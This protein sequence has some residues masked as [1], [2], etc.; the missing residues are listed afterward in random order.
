LISYEANAHILKNRASFLE[1]FNRLS[2]KAK[3]PPSKGFFLPP[4]SNPDL[5]LA[6]IYSYF[7][8]HYRFFGDKLAHGPR[9]ATYEPCSAHRIFAHLLEEFPFARIAL[10]CRRPF[11]NILASTKINGELPLEFVID[12]WLSGIIKIID[13]L[14]INDSSALCSFEQMIE[15]DFRPL[16]ELTGLDFS[17]HIDAVKLDAVTTLQSQAEEYFEAEGRRFA[18]LIEDA[19]ALYLK[20]FTFIDPATGRPRGEPDRAG[21]QQC[22][23][24]FVALYRKF[25]DAAGWPAPS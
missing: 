21:L 12:N 15:A 6:E 25:L 4:L 23:A 14:C 8:Q 10:T 2:T 13:M 18:D 20:T 22:R 9:R 7:L 19:E 3:R 11:T 16:T 24:E 17:K 5:S 1:N